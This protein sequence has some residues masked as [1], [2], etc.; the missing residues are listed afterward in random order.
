MG[1][2]T[3][4]KK[5]FLSDD[6]KCIYDETN[7]EIMKLDNLKSVEVYMLNGLGSMIRIVNGNLTIYFAVPRIFINKGTG[8]AI[9]NRS[10][11]RKAKNKLESMMNLQ[12]M[13]K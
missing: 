10:A 5:G 12:R 8:F 9:I 3:I 1:L 6:V 4:V 11:T 2:E 13:N 7:T